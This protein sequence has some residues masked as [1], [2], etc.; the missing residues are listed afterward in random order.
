ML[1]CTEYNY[2]YDYNYIIVLCLFVCL[3]VCSTDLT[4]RVYKYINKVHTNTHPSAYNHPHH[5]RSPSLDDQHMSS[6]FM[7]VRVNHVSEVLSVM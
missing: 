4:K 3:F 1:S 6:C 7:F 2:D 5:L